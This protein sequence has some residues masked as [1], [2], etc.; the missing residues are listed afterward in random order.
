M[1]SILYL[2]WIGFNNLGDEWMWA[3]FEQMAKLH[4]SPEKYKVIPSMPGVDL[5]D[6]S[7]YDTVVMGGGS[8]LIPGYLDIL[9]EAVR[10][11]KRVIIWGSGHDRL[12]PFS[13]GAGEPA[14]SKEFS[15]KVQEVV[16][17][18]AFCGVRGPWTFEYMRQMGVSMDRVTVS[19]DPAMLASPPASDANGKE[20]SERW[21]GINWG[22]SY[23][24][25]YGKD[26]AYVEKQLASAASFLIEEGYKLYLYP[27][28]G[29]DREACK[30]LYDKIAVSDKVVYDAETHAYEHYLQLMKRFDLTINLK[31]H[32]NVLSAA[33]DVPFICLGY[34]F[35]SF[36]FAHSIGLPQLAISTDASQLAERIL[37]AA[38]HAQ[39][40]RTTILNQIGNHRQAVKANLEQPFLEQLF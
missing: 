16:D 3:M 33:A 24:R 34:R 29:P 31:L 4:L 35:K 21:I 38:A 32:A 17:H 13:F 12:N 39:A 22:T 23:N 27:V 36:D 6:L 20:T 18:A 10:Q 1:K 19:G 25:I 7:G 2:G 30:R 15:V 28:W 5:K 11:E 9:H 37:N 26:E 40:N 14:E 8:L